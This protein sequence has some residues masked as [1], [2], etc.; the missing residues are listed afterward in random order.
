MEWL[1]Q[2]I[3]RAGVEPFSLLRDSVVPRENEHGGFAALSAEVSQDFQSPHLGQIYIQYDYVVFVE[4]QA[5]GAFL[6]IRHGLHDVV[7]R[8][9]PLPDGVAYLFIV[10]DHQYLSHLLT[11]RPAP[12]CPWH[13]PI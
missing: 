12:L 13:Y 10:L 6:S 8:G 5:V 1:G 3:I 4:A 7:V 9:K 2:V 11:T